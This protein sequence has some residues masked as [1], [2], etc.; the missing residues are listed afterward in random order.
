MSVNNSIM[1]SSQKKRDSLTFSSLNFINRLN[2]SQNNENNNKTFS[3]S[4]NPLIENN[5]EMNSPNNKKFCLFLKKINLKE[6]KN[7]YYSK[8]MNNIFYNPK[9]Y[10]NNIYNGKKVI[11]GKQYNKAL[12]LRELYEYYYRI[13]KRRKTLVNKNEMKSLNLFQKVLQRSRSFS[14]HKLEN[15]KTSS[16]NETSRTKLSNTSKLEVKFFPVNDKELQSLYKEIAEREEYNRKQ[17]DKEKSEK[18]ILNKSHVLGIGQML[19]LQEKI[20]KIKRRRNKYNEKMT[21]RIISKTFKEKD[22]ILMNEHKEVLILKGKNTDIDLIKFNISN[23]DL[24]K[25]LKNWIF[26]LRKSKD[27]EEKS[28]MK[29]PEEKIYF[30]KQFSFSPENKEKNIRKLLF[31][32]ISINSKNIGEINEDK[33]LNDTNKNKSLGSLRNLFIQGK[34]LLNQEIKL[35]KDLVGKKKK[36]MQYSF[37]SKDISSML[38]A[39][40]HYIDDIKTPKAIIN[41]METHNYS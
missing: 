40:S 27:E 32:K 6:C 8:A 39:K 10:L 30:N 3:T 1:K 33:K 2:N 12:G 35:S 36:I 16:Y 4:I 7:N 19:N 24:N 34:N 31:R 26:N 23:Y 41:S 14:L 37:P 20:L 15:Y 28:K 21:N 29:S 13:N 11:I 5:S 18:K 38:M 9:N 22:K 17:I 25:N